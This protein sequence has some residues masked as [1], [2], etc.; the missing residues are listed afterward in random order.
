VGYLAALL[1][2][3]CGIK[4]LALFPSIV[5]YATFFMPSIGFS[6]GHTVETPPGSIENV[7]NEASDANYVEKIIPPGGASLRPPAR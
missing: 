4:G 6:L 7:L 2:G 1:A 3:A 5:I